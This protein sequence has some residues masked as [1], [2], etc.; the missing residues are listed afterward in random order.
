MR[1]VWRRR[2]SARIFRKACITILFAD[3][4]LREGTERFLRD[5]ARFCQLLL[6]IWRWP[7]PTSRISWRGVYESAS[8]ADQHDRT[9]LEKSTDL[10]QRIGPLP[11]YALHANPFSEIAIVSQLEQSRSAKRTGAL[12][13]PASMMTSACRQTNR[14]SD[15]CSQVK[16][17]IW[18]TAS[19]SAISDDQQSTRAV[20]PFMLVRNQ[21][22]ETADV[23]LLVAG[24]IRV[25]SASH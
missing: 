21:A 15:N 1:H 10:V 14:F 25:G 4:S 5:S 19:A 3:F 18:R 16:P 20:V 11:I 9:R 6:R 22:S 8:E 7:R 24:A 12:I 2:R 23:P 17:T 13:V